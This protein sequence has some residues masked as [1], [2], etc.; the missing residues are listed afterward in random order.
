MISRKIFILRLTAFANQVDLPMAPPKSS[1]VST[2]NEAI[3]KVESE[4]KHPPKGSAPPTN[5]DV[6]ASK[7]SRESEVEMTD[8]FQK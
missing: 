5:T 3:V 6:R 1:K 2:G 7:T 8:S 4:G